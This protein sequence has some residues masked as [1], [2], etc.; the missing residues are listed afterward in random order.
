[1]RVA[2]LIILNPFQGFNEAKKYEDGYK[3]PVAN[4]VKLLAQVRKDSTRQAQ[5][6]IRQQDSIRSLQ[7][8]IERLHGFTPLHRNSSVQKNGIPADTNNKTVYVNTPGVMLSQQKEP[9]I[10]EHLPWM[11][12]FGLMSVVL[13]FLLW[14]MKWVMK[15]LY[16]F[17][18]L[19][20]PFSIVKVFGFWTLVVWICI[21]TYHLFDSSTLYEVLHKINPFK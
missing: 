18:N 4:T 8:S 10:T 12:K 17:A 1:M 2:V 9:S 21:T 16:G 7:D 19:I 13:L 6:I 5:L 14:A 20:S 3:K 15:L 11:M